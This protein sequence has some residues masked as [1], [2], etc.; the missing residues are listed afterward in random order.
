MDWIAYFCNNLVRFL[1]SRVSTFKKFNYYY[2]IN[3]ISFVSS[4]SF[5]NMK[6]KQYFK[7]TEKNNET[8]YI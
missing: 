4:N 6:I 8:I 7:K 1:F 5:D 3:F 2:N